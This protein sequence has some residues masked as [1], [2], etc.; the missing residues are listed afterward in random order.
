[1]QSGAVAVGRNSAEVHLNAGLQQ[2]GCAR[3]SLGHDFGDLVISDEVVHSHL[4]FG[5]GHENIEIADS[6]LAPAVAA[7]D[8]HASDAGVGLEIRAERLCEVL[9][10]CDL[11]A[12]L[13]L[14]TSLDLGGESSLRFWQ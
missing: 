11:E 2:N 10:R 14:H 12:P 7:G 6:L 3:W 5:A 4:A 13:A 1:M 8:D 9:S